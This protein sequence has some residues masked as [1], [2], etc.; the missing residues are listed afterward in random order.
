MMNAPRYMTIREGYVTGAWFA[1]PSMAMT[2]EKSMMVIM[3]WND[4][5][6]AVVPWHANASPRRS[7]GIQQSGS[8]RALCEVC[9]EIQPVSVSHTKVSVRVCEA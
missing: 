9:Q 4:P 2:S 3:P 8:G 6:T 5:I 7:A 1:F